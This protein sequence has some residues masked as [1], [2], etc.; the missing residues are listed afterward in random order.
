MYFG[1]CNLNSYYSTF[2]IEILSY[3]TSS[4]ILLSLFPQAVLL[5]AIIYGM[6]AQQ[7]Y[8]EIEKTE[9]VIKDVYVPSEKKI[10]RLKWYRRNIQ[11]VIIIYYI[12]IIAIQ[13]LLLSGLHYKPYDLTAFDIYTKVFFLLMIYY[14]IFVG[15]RNK[16]LSE[17]PILIS[18]FLIVFIGNGLNSY[19]KNEALKIIDG[20]SEYKT[21]HLSF[22]YNGDKI[23]TSKSLITVGQTSNFLFLYD[24]KE[25]KTQVYSTSKIDDLEIR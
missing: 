6:L 1:F 5:S 15:D 10:K 4:D 11:W 24:V 2:N 23:Q 14:A 25:K 8:L 7:L 18:I 22:C 12:I 19:R 3:V 13:Q 16:F 21:N 9:K 20:I 17:N